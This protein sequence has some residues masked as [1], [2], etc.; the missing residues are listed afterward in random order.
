MKALHVT[1]YE[2]MVPCTPS[3]SGGGSQVT[4]KF[5]EFGLNT[6]TLTGGPVWENLLIVSGSDQPSQAKQFQ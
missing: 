3:G 1:V 2:S 4:I 5:L 6:V